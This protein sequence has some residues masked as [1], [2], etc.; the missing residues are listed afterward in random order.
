MRPPRHVAMNLSSL[1]YNSKMSMNRLRIDNVKYTYCGCP[2]NMSRSLGGGGIHK[3]ERELIEPR[4]LDRV[5][6]GVRFD[7][8]GAFPLEPLSR[9]S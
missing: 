7:T 6:V 3:R 1:V 5:F 2:A 4:E 9:L 8:P